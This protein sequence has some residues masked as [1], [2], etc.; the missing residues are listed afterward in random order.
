MRLRFIPL[1]FIF[2]AVFQSG[3]S[4]EPTISNRTDADWKLAANHNDVVIYSRPHPGSSLKEFKAVGGIDASTS[5]VHSVIDDVDA[6]SKFMP[7][8]AEC[9]IV[10]R[11]NNSLVTYQRCS[12]KICSDRDYTLRI[13]EKSWPQNSGV[14]FLNSWESANDLGPAKNAGVVRINICNGQWL[15][16]PDGADKTRATYSIYTDTGGLIPAFIANRFSQTAI[17]KIFAA[18]R[19]QAKDPKYNSAGRQQ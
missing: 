5:A 4:S 18:V 7:Y 12:P 17:E 15:L 14:A 10:K 3:F 13:R 8:I 16:E 6:Y 1:P 9:R 11:E 2:L 19:K